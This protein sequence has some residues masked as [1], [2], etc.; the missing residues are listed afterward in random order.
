MCQDL[1]ANGEN[2][3]CVDACIMRCLN[4]VDIEDMNQNENLTQNLPILPD[5]SITQPSLFVKAK[6]QAFDKNFNKQE[7]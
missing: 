1:L 5:S 3:A 7:Y 2:P 6:P 4:I